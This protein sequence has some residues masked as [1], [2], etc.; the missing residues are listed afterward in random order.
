MNTSEKL[1]NDLIR[2]QYIPGLPERK[3][4]VLSAKRYIV[5]AEMKYKHGES[6]NLQNL[7]RAME[8]TIE[9]K[10]KFK[11]KIQIFSTYIENAMN[12]RVFDPRVWSEI[13][14]WK[15]V[16]I[17]NVIITGRNGISLGQEVEK[18]EDKQKLNVIEH[19]FK[20]NLK[21][22]KNKLKIIQKL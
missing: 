13:R 7:A 1:A 6:I 2:N 16:K 3:N 11:G 20:K 14:T 22:W 8:E 15:D 12:I 5:G 18:D 19:K 10:I 17:G 4:T 21:Y 9:R